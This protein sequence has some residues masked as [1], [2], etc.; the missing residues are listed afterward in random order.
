MR[1]DISLLFPYETEYKEMTPAA[2]HDLCID[3]LCK[4]MTSN[5]KEQYLIKSVLTNLTPDPKVA[6]FRSDIMDDVVHLPD[7]REK[8][9]QLLEKVA[10]I[11]DFGILKREIGSNAG[12]W[13]LMHK[14]E[15]IRDYIRCVEGIHECLSDADIKSEGLIRLRDYVK[16]TY[17][18]AM[19]A[20][21]KEDIDNISCQTN[22]I[23]SVTVGIN[24]NQRFEASSIGLVSVNNKPF[25]NSGILHNFSSAKGV[26]D[27]TDWDGDMHFKPIEK[28]SSFG[29]NLTR[30]GGFMALQK[31]PL[32]DS[33]TRS[34]IVNIPDDDAN[35]SF[36]RY[37][38]QVA[39][40][41]MNLLVKQLREVLVKYVSLSI[42]SITDLIPEFTYYVR[43]AQLLDKLTGRGFKFTKPVVSDSGE[44]MDAQGIYNI[45][46]VLEGE[47]KPD[48]VV[49][50]N[51]DF[52]NDNLVYILTGAN[53]GGKTT[54]TQAIGQLYVMAQGGMY[55]P[56]SCF[57]YVPVDNIYTHFPAD[58]D[59]T[60]D[61]GR[62]GEECKRFKEMYTEATDKS[63]MLLNETFSTTS[64]EEGYYI[65]ADS[66]K[67]IL[68][69]GIRT[70]YNTHMH[71]LGFELPKETKAVS[72]IVQKGTYKVVK[73]QPEGM[74][75][76][77]D[78]ARRYGVTYDML[79]KED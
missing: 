41:M 78:I 47:I 60:L 23:A 22:E 44:L 61:L 52:D 13:E 29:V 37:I 9:S 11:K 73:T 40:R 16:N 38:D 5:E 8:L 31:N 51:L 28:S 62:L 27:G 7:M 42:G 14:L 77:D 54:I 35:S 21:L 32:I 46:L 66:I 59:K 39:S 74:S 12:L 2:A 58:E 57:K 56:A 65:A 10:V 24:L 33:S 75:Y 64:F 53:R 50:N 76:A 79:T 34:S 1:T 70:I 69:K 4:A 72:I 6:A 25:K 3:M 15:E 49:T 55:V 36:P 18:D 20:Q 30:L 68:H 19:Y 26:Q 45:K 43:G 63:L 67:A 17:E 48:A 71:K